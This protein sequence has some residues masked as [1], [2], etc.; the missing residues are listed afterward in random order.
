MGNTGSIPLPAGEPDAWVQEWSEFVLGTVKA[1]IN[2]RLCS[3]LG[4][5]APP[6]LVLVLPCSGV[7]P[8]PHL[9]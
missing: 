2:R 8:L 7:W 6:C 3:P 4:A 5:S 9:P 1:L